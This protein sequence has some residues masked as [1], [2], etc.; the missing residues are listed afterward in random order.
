M[1]VCEE[2]VGGRL[3][4]LSAWDSDLLWF[5]FLLG[6]LSMVVIFLCSLHT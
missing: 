3:G 2:V 5:I 1:L 6:M 4:R